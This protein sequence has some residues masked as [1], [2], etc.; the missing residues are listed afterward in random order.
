MILLGFLRG[1]CRLAYVVEDIRSRP[2][3]DRLPRLSVPKLQTAP[4]SNTTTL[5][6]SS[7][8]GLQT[9][10]PLHRRF[11][12]QIWRAQHVCLVDMCT[13]Q[14][15]ADLTVE[16]LFAW[17]LPC[18]STMVFLPFIRTLCPAYP[19]YI[20][21]RQAPRT[22]RPQR[23]LFLAMRPLRQCATLCLRYNTLRTSSE[24][25]LK[26][27]H[28]HAPRPA[29]SPL[30]FTRTLRLAHAACHGLATLPPP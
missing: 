19:S 29:A 9:F 20:A 13:R 2:R 10:N 24:R 3:L 15:K 7:Q 1:S 21:P 17:T 8:L 12:P 28:S 27:A 6:R 14:I 22:Q 26:T 23:A 4:H 25:A 18:R 30:P 16:Q 11:Q 5:A